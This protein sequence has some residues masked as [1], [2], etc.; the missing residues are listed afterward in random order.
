MHF[1]DAHGFHP[2]WWYLL[3]CCIPHLPLL[4]YRHKNIQFKV[5][6]NLLSLITSTHHISVKQT[7][8]QMM[9]VTEAE[10]LLLWKGNI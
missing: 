10:L 7:S 3:P 4:S 5:T 6:E 9:H 8:N 2:R 1:I